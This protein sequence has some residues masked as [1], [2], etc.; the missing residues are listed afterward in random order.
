MKF[1]DYRPT[2][3]VCW[4]HLS[5]N[6]RAHFTSTLSSISTLAKPTV[7]VS[8]GDIEVTETA[9]NKLINSNVR[10]WFAHNATHT[11]H[12]LTPLPIFLP[13][14][15]HAE[16]F[17]PAYLNEALALPK[18]DSSNVL[19]CLNPEDQRNGRER[20]QLIARISALPH[21]TVLPYGRDLASRKNFLRELRA[22]RFV[23]CPRGCGI[24]TH[25]IWEALYLG[26]IP[27]VQKSAIYRELSLPIVWVDSFDSIPSIAEL[28]DHYDTLHQQDWDFS[29]LNPDWWVARINQ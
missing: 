3:F 1:R 23:L 21:V 13:D 12:R 17:D 10:H 2:G 25:K 27:I 16:M 14:K 22:H 20:A 11:D 8:G 24:D 19:C 6:C 9:F 7:V 29:V 15:S 26:V 28:T 4:D 5:A 18:T